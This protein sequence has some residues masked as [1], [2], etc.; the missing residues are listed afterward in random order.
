MRRKVDT[1]CSR[2]AVELFERFLHRAFD[3]SAQMCTVG[4][5]YAIEHVAHQIRN[6]RR[7]KLAVSPYVED[8]G[9]RFP[10][11]SAKQ[12]RAVRKFLFQ[13]KRDRPRVGDHPAVMFEDRDLVLAAEANRRFVADSNGM[14]GE[15]EALVMQC[16]AGPPGI[17]A[18]AAIVTAAKF[19]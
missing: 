2:P 7:D 1:A 17:G 11:L 16:Q 8:V 18:E 9:E 3:M 5:I 14:R 4:F 19:P 15:G 10:G 12:R 13:I 6:Q